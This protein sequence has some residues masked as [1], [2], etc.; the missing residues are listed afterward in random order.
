MNLELLD[1]CNFGSSDP[2]WF[3][4]AVTPLRDGRL[5][6]TMQKISG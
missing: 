6:A 3:H 4:P 2:A 5:F 1:F